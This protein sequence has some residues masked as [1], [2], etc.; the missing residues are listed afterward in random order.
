MANLVRE[1]D[2]I[3]KPL[4]A[5]GKVRDL[6]DL[7][8]S[9]LIVVTDRVSAFD[10]V[11]NELIPQ[12]GIVLNSIAA[13]WFEKTRSI[14]DNHMIS[15][16]PLTYPDGLD[17][18]ADELAGRSMLVRKIDMLPVECIVRGY[19]EGS[20]LKEYRAIQSISGIPMPAGLR[21]AD[22]LPEPIFTPSTKADSGHDENISF[23]Q[24]VSV[25]G[26]DLAEQLR[27]VS[28]QLYRDAAAYAESKGIIL[29]D[30]KFEFGLS[31][32]QLIVADEMF[33]PDS[34][35]FWELDDYQPG[36]SQK[37]FDKQYLRE[38]LE[39]LDWDK[40]PPPPALPES[41]IQATAA[42]YLEAYERLTGKSL[43]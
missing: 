16:D 10:V 24:L 34:S 27:S 32:G 13:F 12:K 7:G 35:R 31:N 2:F 22:R 42:K 40:N 39:T 38:W 18:Y 30:T 29:A 41:V 4:L 43:G 11:F 21:Q 19:L 36:R 17:R 28:L 6:F 25:I 20:A 8:Q 37:S 23:D 1:T 5:R 33:T 9:L 3:D 26:S 14:I 15:T